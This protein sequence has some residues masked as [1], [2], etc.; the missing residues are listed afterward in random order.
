[1]DH[2]LIYNGISEGKQ[3]LPALSMAASLLKQWG[4]PFINRAEEVPLLSRDRACEILDDLPG[5]YMPQNLLLERDE[6]HAMATTS[7]QL[8]EF[9]VQDRFPILIRTSRSKCQS[10]NQTPDSDF[11]ILI[12]IRTSA[13]VPLGLYIL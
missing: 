8:S 13:E 6:V 4:K 12:L 3:N 2:E 7:G 10:P 11:P 9:L 5:T 1:M